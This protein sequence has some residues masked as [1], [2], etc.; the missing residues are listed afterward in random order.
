MTQYHEFVSAPAAA[1]GE[2]RIARGGR[3]ALAILAAAMFAM[4]IGVTAIALSPQSVAPVQ[5]A[6]E[7]PVTDGWL[8]AITAA[9]EARRAAAASEVVD[10]WMPRLFANDEQILDGWA[11]RYL[12]ADE[13]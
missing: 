4:V 3:Y 7:R 13:D 8:P 9:N 6:A 11:V 10:G 1:T 5:P 2:A 12:V